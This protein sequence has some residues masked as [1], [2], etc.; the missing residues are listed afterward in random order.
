MGLINQLIT[1]GGPQPGLTFPSGDD[2]YTNTAHV[3]SHVTGWTWIAARDYT[4]HCKRS[5]YGVHVHEPV[6]TIHDT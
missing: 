4:N 1:F 3:L 5:Q 6:E 2:M